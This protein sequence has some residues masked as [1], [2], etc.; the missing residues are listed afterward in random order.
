MPEQDR[1]FAHAS[2]S[3]RELITQAV[4]LLAGQP[5]LLSGLGDEL[6]KAFAATAAARPGGGIQIGG[7]VQA[8]NLVIGTGNVQAVASEVQAGLLRL[9]P[10]DA[11][12]LLRRSAPSDAVLQRAEALGLAAASHAV[13]ER[14]LHPHRVDLE[15]SAFRVRLAALERAVGVVELGGNRC[16]TCFAVESDLVLTCY[17]V[18]APC[19]EQPG[20]AR[21]LRIVFDYAAAGELDG[22][23]SAHALHGDWCAGHSPCD[24]EA[25]AEPQSHHLDYC[26]LRLAPRSPNEQA[27]PPR[28]CIPLASAR[29]PRSGDP[30]LILQHPRGQRLKLGFGS[31]LGFDASNTRVRYDTNTDFGSSGAPCF[32][33]GLELVAMHQMA[34]PGTGAARDAKYNQGLTATQLLRAL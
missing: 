17:H 16:G 8:T 25:S 20:L 21:Q 34:A 1:A 23:H 3:D 10:R 11:F 27:L 24:A 22:P 28:P 19:F 6:A 32:N 33:E 4:A 26:L 15:P 18:V 14:N 9:P 7:N 30:L 13:F 29:Q 31:V 12:D 5:E 2:P